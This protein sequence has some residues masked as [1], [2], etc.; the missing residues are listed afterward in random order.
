[1]ARYDEY[2]AALRQPFQKLCRLRFLNPDG[3]T[4][5]LVD[6]NVANRRSGAFIDSGS[7]SMRYQNGR[8]RNADVTIAN[9]DGAFDYNVDRLWFGSEIALDEGLQL[10][11]GEEFYIQQGVFLIETPD[12]T[13]EP[14]R[15]TIDYHLVDK[16]ANLDGTLM[17]NLEG[18][19]EVK[20]G[21][22]VFDPIAAL[23]AEDRGNGLPLDRVTPVFTTWYNGKRQALPNGGTALLTDVPYDLEVDTTKWD[24][25]AKLCGM[26]NAWV[27]YDESGA[28]R[29]DPSQDDIL[30][31]DKPIAWRFS[32]DE[33]QILG[34]T[35][36]LLNAQIYNDYIV[37]GEMMDDYYQP[38]GR[39]QNLDPAS[40]TNIRTIGR[41][42]FRETAAGY[43]TDTQC[44]DRANWMLKRVS[45]LQKSVSVSCSQMFHIHGNE[46][47]TIRRTDK[48][49][50]P[51]ERHLVMGYSRPLTG[52]GAMT[53]ECVSTADLPF[54]TLSTNNT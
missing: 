32:L 49:G 14:A 35:Y 44:M 46:L 41:K 2:L 20:S 50:A 25:V 18:M 39:A 28:L 17:G 51:E 16:V 52:T 53:L 6:N 47:V 29:V 45:I 43:A 8:R 1:M 31:A 19:Y 15:R 7:V 48:P 21:T 40:D 3:S 11:T 37:I 38:T 27:G 34:A 23:L 36:Q 42:T 30:D 10:P 9:V 5:F 54:A 4:A 24:V 22:N 13:L 12:E 26:L 33:A